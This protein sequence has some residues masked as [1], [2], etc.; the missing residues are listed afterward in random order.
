MSSKAL[1]ITAIVL[2]AL[3][4]AIGRYTVPEKVRVE[5]KIVTVE[6]KTENKNTDVKDHKKITVIE[7]DN[8]DG[9]KTKTTTTTDDS[10][11]RVNDKTT[12]SIDT[13]QSSV[14]ETIRGSSKVTISLLAGTKLSFSANPIVFGGIISKPL[15]GPITVSVY[16]LSDASGGFGLGLQF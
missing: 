15:L 7:I 1:I 11:K 12:D 5:T 8:K 4:A 14:T 9:S 13:S 2:F 6:K 3:G 10:D 16:G